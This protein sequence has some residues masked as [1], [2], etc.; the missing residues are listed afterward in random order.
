VVSFGTASG[1]PSVV[2]PF[3]FGAHVGAVLCGY[4]VFADI[5][6]RPAGADLTALA[7]QALEGEL[8]IDVAAQVD[9]HDLDAV[10]EAVAGVATGGGPAGKTVLLL[11]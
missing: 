4:V 10:G 1:Q 5:A 6:A 8:L 9:A 11:R 2:P 7:R 3:W